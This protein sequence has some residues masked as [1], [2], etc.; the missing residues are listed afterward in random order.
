VKNVAKLLLELCKFVVLVCASI[1][2]I[3][4]IAEAIKTF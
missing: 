1:G 3:A 4:F 2:L